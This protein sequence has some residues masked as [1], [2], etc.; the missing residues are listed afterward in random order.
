MA[1]PSAL[2]IDIKRE[3][4]AVVLLLVKSD[5]DFASASNLEAAIKAEGS[6]PGQR[7]VVSLVDSNWCDSSGIGVFLRAKRDLGNRFAIVLPSDH[8]MRQVF[9][10]T[11]LTEYLS[12]Y[13]TRREAI[14]A[15]SLT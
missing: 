12:I 14:D 5:V 15:T 7:I 4:G 8:Q 1:D 2:V 6:R 10:V 9:N 3:A 13:P 11:H